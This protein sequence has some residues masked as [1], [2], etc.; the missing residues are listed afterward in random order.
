M[1]FEDQDAPPDLVAAGDGLSDEETS[2][3]V[4]ITI[5][6][7][8]VFVCTFCRVRSSPCAD[9]C[10]S[11]TRLSRSW[12]NYAPEL[13]IDSAAWQKDRRDHEWCGVS[14]TNF[15]NRKLPLILN[16]EFGD[17]GFP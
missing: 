8:K 7:G 1:D 4:P 3:K 17:C 2:V 14:L 5:V 6:T 16:P 15:E 10:I 9:F 12:Q 11:S 13:Y